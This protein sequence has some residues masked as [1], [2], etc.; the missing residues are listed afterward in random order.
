MTKQINILLKR[1]IWLDGYTK[2]VKQMIRQKNIQVE[3]NM[4]NGYTQMVKQVIK[5][6]I[7]DDIYKDK[8]VGR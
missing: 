2:M 3:R 8:S 1:N 7:N 5:K 6:I 4:L